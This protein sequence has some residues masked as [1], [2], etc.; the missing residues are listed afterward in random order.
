MS[1]LDADVIEKVAR[2]AARKAER[3]AARKAAR[4]TEKQNDK[5]KAEMQQEPTVTKK[6]KTTTDREGDDDDISDYLAAHE[7]VIHEE[8]A[9]PPCR[10]LR[11]APFPAPLIR[12][13]ESQG[14]TEPSPVQAAAWPIAVSGRDVLAIAKTGSGKTLGFLLPVLAKCMIEK[15]EAN[16]GPIGVIMAPTRELAL[17]IHAEAVKF[18]RGANCRAVAVY[19]GTARD[20]QVRA[21]QQGCE[22]IIGTPGRIKDVLDTRGGGRDAVCDVSHMSQL[23]LDE[24]DR[25][26]DMGFEADIRAIVWRCFENRAHQT[27]LFSATWPPDVQGIANDLL[28]NPVKVTVGSGGYKLTANKSVTQRVHVITHSQRMQKFEELIQPFTKGGK[29]AGKRV[30]VFANMKFM[31]KK[32]TQYCKSKGMSAESMSGDRSQSQRESTVRKFKDGRVTVV[33][34][35]DVAARGLDIKGIERV[36]NYELPLTDFQDYVHRIGRT[37]RAG[38]TGEADSLFTESDRKYST[39]LIRIMKEA[40]QEVPPLLAKFGPTKIVFHYDSD[41]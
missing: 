36:I 32:L 6:G 4:K 3:K 24:A 28:T 19:G 34:A 27:S 26:L 23:V 20:R 11:N 13:L 1:N 41:E 40:G 33:I 9:P 38:A 7:I 18:G 35:T 25:M 15:K 16:G 31:V 10:S 2:K 22:L 39:E 14:F 21:L 8:G 30:I 29:D 17:Q 12:V 37:G 5:R